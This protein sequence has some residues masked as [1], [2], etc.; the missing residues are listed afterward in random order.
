MSKSYEQFIKKNNIVDK[1]LQRSIANREKLYS[2]FRIVQDRYNSG[3]KDLGD[4]SDFSK[5]TQ[6]LK[7]GALMV[8][9]TKEINHI[10]KD[11]G[12]SDQRFNK[13]NVA[14]LETAV[15]KLGT[16][17]LKD[18]VAVKF[19]EEIEQIDVQTKKFVELVQQHFDMKLG[20]D[21][22]LLKFFQDFILC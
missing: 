10:T 3:K 17:M 20:S 11:I 12:I 19:Q 4:Y 22:N 15:N 21:H 5:N 7:D 6:V 13:I 14:T 18:G 16:S 1:K 2:A 8:K 9:L